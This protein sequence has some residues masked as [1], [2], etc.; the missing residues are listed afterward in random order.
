M[1][2][3]LLEEQL[4]EELRFLEYLP[5]PWL[6][7]KEGLLD[8]AIIGG[9]MAGL[10]AAFGLMREGIS[11]IQV[12]DECPEGFEGPWATFARMRILRSQKALVG[13]A[14]DIPKLTYQAWYR[15]QYGEEEWEKLYKI[16]TLSWMEYLRWYR[17]VLNIP[18][19]NGCQVTL[20][21]P[22]EDGLQLTIEGKPSRMARKVV[23]ATGRG[24]FGKW[25]VPELFRHLPKDFYAHTSEWIDFADFNGKEVC[26]LG[27]GSSG[28]DAAAEALEKG[29]SSVTI[30]EQRQ[31]I[32]FINK[33]ASTFYCGIT[34]GF[35]DLPDEAKIGFI[36][37]GFD[38]GAPPPFESLDRV[39]GYSNFKVL[40]GVEI[41]KVVEREGSLILETNRGQ[42]QC[43]F[44][45][46]A[47]GFAVDVHAQE[48]LR[49]FADDILLWKER[50]SESG[51]LG[52]APYLGTHFEFQE[53]V[54]GRAPALKHLYCYN[55][56]ATL[57]HGNVS[58]D[59]PAIGAGAMRL[60]KGI[61]C[62][63]FTQ[64]W[65]VYLQRLHAYTTPEFL[66]G[67]YPFIL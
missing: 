21:E 57:S 51:S 33:F 12:F 61:A 56:A 13:P 29:A 47:T 53:K 6:P 24:G 4:L 46:F 66:A 8:V 54:S 59:I 63:F 49:A 48:E 5:K 34:E 28:F 25:I 10:A 64:N 1:S 7:E 9:G 32:P 42:L 18:M 60:A 38:T 2:L 67:D 43:V 20:I 30:L 36:Q 15:A 16:P 45:V 37:H 17:R 27:A 3:Q 31:V 50:Y 41:E 39:K 26:I 52:N 65:L 22:S 58:G 35:Y 23:L 55:Y 44:T 11:N 40:T 62:D 19:Q 14:L